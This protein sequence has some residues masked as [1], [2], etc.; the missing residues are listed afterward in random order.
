MYK[1]QTYVE[2]SVYL[3]TYIIQNG[4]NNVQTQRN[5]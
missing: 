2:Y 3:L 1:L 5:P 4:S